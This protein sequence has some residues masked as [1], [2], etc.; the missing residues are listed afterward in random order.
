MAVAAAVG[1]ERAM[2]G[3]R[4]AG[5]SR[6]LVAVFGLCLVGS[7]LSAP[8]PMAGFPP[9]A[10]SDGRCRPGRGTARTGPTAQPA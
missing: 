4:G 1:L 3:S 9:G 5:A 10:T 7:G 8:D 2:R 6:L